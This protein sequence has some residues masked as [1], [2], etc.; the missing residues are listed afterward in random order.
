MRGQYYLIEPPE[1]GGHGGPVSRD[2]NPLVLVDL[3]QAL[4]QPPH[5]VVQNW[6]HGHLGPGVTFRK[7]KK[8][9]V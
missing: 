8:K 6:L 3:G 7:M 1:Q 5:E 4:V 9:G 2:V